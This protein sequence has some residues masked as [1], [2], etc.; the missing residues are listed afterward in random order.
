MCEA[1]LQAACTTPKPK[2]LTPREFQHFY[3][4]ADNTALNG[5]PKPQGTSYAA[6]V[7]GLQNEPQDI[8]ERCIKIL[9]K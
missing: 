4:R 2:Y 5:G 6:A 9:A 7:L 3:L 8:L 1:F